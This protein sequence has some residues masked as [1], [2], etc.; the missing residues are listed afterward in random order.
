MIDAISTVLTISIAII[1][2]LNMHCV[3]DKQISLQIIFV[4]TLIKYCEL[5]LL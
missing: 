2:D 5:Y 3:C 1:L 4:I